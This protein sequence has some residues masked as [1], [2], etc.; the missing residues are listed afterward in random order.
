M[1]GGGI[2]INPSISS[3]EKCGMDLPSHSA[4]V[5]LVIIIVKT[6]QLLFVGNQ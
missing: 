2:S 6:H 4:M 1:P 5:F 3:M